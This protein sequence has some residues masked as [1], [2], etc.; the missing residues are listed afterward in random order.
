MLQ[1]RYLG[2]VEYGEALALQEELIEKRGAQEIPDTLLLLEHPP[3]ITLGRGAKEHNLLLSREEYAARGVAVEEI[4]RGGDVTYHG[5]GQL[6]GYPILD[7][8]GG[9]EDV[10]K[11]VASL[12]Q[13][14]ID[15][16][17]RYGIVA[18]RIDGMNGSWVGVNDRPRKIGAVGVRISRWITKHGFAFNGTTNL[19]HFSWIVPCGLVGKGVT[20]VE[21]ETG[22]TVNP[23]A[24]AGVAAERLAELQSSRLEWAGASPDVTMVPVSGQLSSRQ[25][26]DALQIGDLE[27][28]VGDAR[29][30]FQ[31]WD[32]LGSDRHPSWIGSAIEWRQDGSE[33]SAT[34]RGM[35][36]P[37]E[38]ALWAALQERAA[39]P[40]G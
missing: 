23:R 30:G 21:A 24:M 8:N 9:R 4:G 10:R 18:E 39:K 27:V 16:A 38:S 3:T 35:L 25:V 32:I 15:L 37:P 31:R 34:F 29:D 5:P 26:G 7:L 33:L 36:R 20:S 1:A 6:V 14:M 22:L 13:T 28:R 19:E 12:E 2:L 11:Y 17:A 40:T